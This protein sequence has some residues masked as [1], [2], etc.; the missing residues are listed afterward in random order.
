MLLIF[1]I[2]FLLIG[3]YFSISQ[4]EQITFKWDYDAAT[5]ANVKEFRFFF[6]LNDGEYDFKNPVAVVPLPPESIENGDLVTFKQ[7][8]SIGLPAD[9]K[10]T[11]FF[12][13][14][15]A[16]EF[17]ESGDSNEVQYPFSTV[18]LPAVVHFEIIVNIE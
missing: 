18:K 7:M 5:V 17:N 12:V 11:A 15:A 8:I 6:R 10:G 13:I 3:I 4:A 14:R 9:T 16:D 2:A 1:G